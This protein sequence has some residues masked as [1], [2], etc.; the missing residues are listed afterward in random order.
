MPNFPIVNAIAPNAPM[1]A[2]R[3]MNHTIPNITR[4]ISLSRFITGR[5]C[6]PMRASA[7]PKSNASSSTWRISPSAKAL[8]K[9]FGIMFRKKPTV[10]CALPCVM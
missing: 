4:A 7:N 8:T 5:P 9:V 1:G 10:L 2:R 6:S 3:V